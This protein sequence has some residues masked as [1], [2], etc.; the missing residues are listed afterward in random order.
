[1]DALPPEIINVILDYAISKP[2]QP[3][4]PSKAMA[5]FARL[6]NSF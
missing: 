3:P 2:D 4:D 5:T 6:Q 1:M